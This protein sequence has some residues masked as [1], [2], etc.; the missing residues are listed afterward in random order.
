MNYPYY[1]EIEI[2]EDYT[3]FD[4]IS[5]G[6]KGNIPKRILFTKIVE[7]NIYNLSFGD[8]IED[9]ID[10][11]SISDNRDMAMILATVAAATERF[12]KNYPD[13]FVYFRGS[14]IERTRLYRMA[15][16]NNIADLN[17]TY[18]IWGFTE[19]GTLSPFVPN[20]PYSAFLIQI[21]LINLL[22]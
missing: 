11:Y 10:D 17:K 19:A 3:T 14:T 6:S 21:K 16:G 9:E 13:R 18:S 1:K 15:I 20:T 12:L 2:S 5:T 4:F 7:P 8:Y 22:S